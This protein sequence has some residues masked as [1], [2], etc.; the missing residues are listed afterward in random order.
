MTTKTKT[1]RIISLICGILP[2]LVLIAGGTM[3]LIGAEPETVMQFLTKMGY[4]GGIHVLGILELLIAALFLYPKTNRIGFLLAISYF[5]GAL[6]LEIAGAQ[7]PVS[8]LFAT[9]CWIS[10]FLKHPEMFLPAKA[11][12]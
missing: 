11:V 6:S 12:K 7:S 10:M 1:K 8:A 5:G 3:K 4:A 2:A 9:L